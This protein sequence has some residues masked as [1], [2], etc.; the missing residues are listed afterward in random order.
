MKFDFDRNAKIK[1]LLI[2]AVLIAAPYFA[3]FAIDF[4][5]LADFMGLEALLVFLF[6][7][8]RSARAVIQVRISEFKSSISATAQLV[9]ELHIFK[10]HVYAT[11]ATV[12]TVLAVF[13]CSIFL[14]CVVWL[15]VMVMSMRYIS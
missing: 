6:A 4:I 8:S 10:P 9:A 7:Y 2:V 1:I 14:A 11:H 15:P 5:I 3:P 13:A 12:S